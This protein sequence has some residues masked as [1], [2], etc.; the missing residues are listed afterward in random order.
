MEVKRSGKIIET[1]M[2]HRYQEELNREQSMHRL[3]FDIQLISLLLAGITLALLALTGPLQLTWLF[4]LLAGS[5]PCGLF[6]VA[7]VTASV[8]RLWPRITGFPAY[9]TIRR[10]LQ[11]AP[12]PETQMEECMDLLDEATSLSTRSMK[13]QRAVLMAAQICQY[14]GIA[15]LAAAFVTG[16]CLWL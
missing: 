1:L 15:C 8:T 5:I 16:L 7:A 2:E 11:N 9:E 4:T 6:L 12:D 3:A 10:R 13:Q 14:A